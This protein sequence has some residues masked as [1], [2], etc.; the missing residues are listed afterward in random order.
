MKALII[1]GLLASLFGAGCKP[2]ATAPVTPAQEA[3]G[4]K[5][6]RNIADHALS[7]TPEAF[8]QLAD[9]R[10]EK[11]F[12][13]EGMYPGAP[14]PEIR[15]RSELAVNGMLDRLSAGLRHSPQKTFVISEFLRMLKAF[16]SED[17][18]EREQACSYCERVM[19]IVGIESSDGALNTW[20]YGFDPEQ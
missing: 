12:Q 10:A 15:E 18:E 9:L 3:D 11:K 14:T 19:D 2:A 5:G 17:T 4:V 6:L 7:L 20:L 1:L 16:E 8:Q 13:E